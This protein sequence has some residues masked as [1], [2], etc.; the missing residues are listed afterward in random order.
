MTRDEARDVLAFHCEGRGDDDV[1]R[2]IGFAID[3]IERLE[4]IRAELGKP[5][6]TLGGQ[7][8][9]VSIHGNRLHELLHATTERDQ[10]GAA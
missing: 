3:A 4:A 5:V 8:V 1:S 7:D 9:Y 10:R 2:A 6:T